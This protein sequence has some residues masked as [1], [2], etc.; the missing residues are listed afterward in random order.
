MEEVSLWGGCASCR[1]GEGRKVPDAG[2]E[3]IQPGQEGCGPGSPPLSF[4]QNCSFV[5]RPLAPIHH[6]PEAQHQ[7]L[8]RGPGW[9][10]LVA[11]GPCLKYQAQKGSQGR[12]GGCGL[13]PALPHYIQEGSCWPPSTKGCRSGRKESQFLPNKSSAQGTWGL[14]PLLACSASSS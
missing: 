10:R 6:G 2:R 9:G 5:S 7:Q 13:A 3:W 14:G 8:S 11:S 1:W 12:T 4:S